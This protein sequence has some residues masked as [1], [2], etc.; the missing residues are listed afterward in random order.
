MPKTKDMQIS[1]DNIAGA[2]KAIQKKIIKEVWKDESLRAKFLKDPKHCI[3]ELIGHHFDKKLKLRIIDSA[4][5]TITFF[6]PHK[7]EKLLGKG[8]FSDIQLDA[9]AG[10]GLGFDF[11]MLNFIPFVGTA[12][13]VAT[14]AVG[15]AAAAGDKGAAKAHAIMKSVGEMLDV[16]NF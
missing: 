9:V 16:T 1:A 3:E 15:V 5:N 10:G 12:A 7:K 6:L 4:D 13:S 2:Y 8:E 11:S 14:S